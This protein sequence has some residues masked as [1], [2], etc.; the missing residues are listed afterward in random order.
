MYVYL[1]GTTPS[2]NPTY[3]WRGELIPFLKENKIDFFN[4]VVEEW[5]QD[6]IRIEDE[7]KKLSHV[8]LFVI[9]PLMEGVY[10]I[11]ELM[12]CAIKAQ[13][14]ETG[15]MVIFCLLDR[16]FDDKVDAEWSKNQMTSFD[17]VGKRI[18]QLGGRYLRSMPELKEFLIQWKEHLDD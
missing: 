3:G 17:I 12:E 15:Q 1:G 6:C 9:T 10:S 18:S 5:D 14:Q 2:H 7:K 11:A 8:N 4:S 16:E 13:S